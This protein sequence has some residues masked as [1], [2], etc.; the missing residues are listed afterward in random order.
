MPVSQGPASASDQRQQTR[1]DDEQDEDR[2][3]NTV[4]VHR[5]RDGGNCDPGRGEPCSIATAQHLTTL[6]W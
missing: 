4:R 6:T 5:K 2:V 1:T 3:Q